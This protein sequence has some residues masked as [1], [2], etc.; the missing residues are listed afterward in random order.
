MVCKEICLLHKHALIKEISTLCV[1][2]WLC[3]ID[4][5]NPSLITQN[6]FRDRKLCKILQE[7]TDKLFVASRVLTNWLQNH[8]FNFVLIATYYAC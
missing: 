4:F 1:N 7:I 5:I 3:N 6:S 8:R 2:A